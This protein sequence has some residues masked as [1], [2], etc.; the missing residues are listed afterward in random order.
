MMKDIYFCKTDEEWLKHSEELEYPIHV[1]PCSI[2]IDYDDDNC[3][4]RQLDNIPAVARLNHIKQLGIAN[5]CRNLAGS[6]QTRYIHSLIC[7]T[8]ID[9]LA[10]MNNL[11]RELAVTAAMMHDMATTPYSDSV[12]KKLKLGDEANFESVLNS[13]TGAL[14]FLD[15]HNISKKELC[16]LVTG[17]DKSVLG[18]LVSSKG[19]IDVDRWS[20]TIYDA[21]RIGKLSSVLGNPYCPDPFKSMKIIDNTVVFEDVNEVRKFLETRV[22]MFESVYRNDELMAKEAFVGEL[23]K[24]MWEKGIINKS[25]IFRLDDSQ[26]ESLCH[27]YNEEL[28]ARIFHVGYFDSYGKLPAGEEEVRQ[29]MAGIT[30]RPFVVKK[31]FSMN[32]ATDTPVLF[33]GK[34]KPYK[35]IDMPHSNSLQMRADSFKYTAVYGFEEDSELAKAVRK[36]EAKFG[37]VNAPTE[38]K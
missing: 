25:N 35:E 13:S 3:I 9:Y 8:K 30:D 36:A 18:Q 22:Y 6:G 15:K 16:D 32:P 10:Q 31:G 1:T 2:I 34:V 20:Y 11:N 29:F 14:A 5:E 4:Y 12:S 7:A 38:T 27:R 17:K 33:K 28:S 26:F 37:R 23:A 19:S 24:E 21:Q